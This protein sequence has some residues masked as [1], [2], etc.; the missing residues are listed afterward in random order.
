MQAHE[1]EINFENTECIRNMIKS[2]VII[3]ECGSRYIVIPTLQTT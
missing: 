3:D 1:V 2:K